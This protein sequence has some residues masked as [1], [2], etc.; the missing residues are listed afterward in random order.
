MSAS[1]TDA[2]RA[3]REHV[4]RV[5]EMVLADSWLTDEELSIAPEQVAE[6]CSSVAH[7]A[8]W[9]P[10]SGGL[11]A[12]E[13]AFDL[14]DGHEERSELAGWVDPDGVMHFDPRCL[15]R[16]T[17]LHELAH[18]LDGR[19]AHGVGFQRRMVEL[20]RVGLGDELAAAL[21]GAYVEG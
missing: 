6:W 11:P 20:V 13:V 5:E 15:D 8:G 16:W 3:D 14:P 9:G 21:E 17:V 12:F 18:S 4:Y 19:D 10:L 2:N 7:R 1:V